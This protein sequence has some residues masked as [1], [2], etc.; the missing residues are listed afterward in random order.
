MFTAR[1]TSS[2]KVSGHICF[3]SSSFVSTRPWF[4]TR[5]RRVSKAFGVSETMLPSHDRT[6]SVG[7]KR[8][9]PNSYISF[10]INDI[11]DLQ[12]SFKKSQ[13]GPKDTYDCSPLNHEQR[14]Q[15]SNRA[16]PRLHSMKPL[17]RG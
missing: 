15:E 17:K 7:S 6:R 3:R 5:Q 11:G 16:D 14:L 1:L 9:G 12:N 2:T 10:S 8:K 13:A 4:R